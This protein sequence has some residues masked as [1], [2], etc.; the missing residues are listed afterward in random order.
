LLYVA[1][2]RKVPPTLNEDLEYTA[3][4]VRTFRVIT[5]RAMPEIPT[6]K[7]T[8]KGSLFIFCAQQTYLIMSNL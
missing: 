2:C 3:Y 7:Q 4:N 5:V 6:T 8:Y 1:F